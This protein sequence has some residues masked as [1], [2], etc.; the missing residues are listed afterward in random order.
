MKEEPKSPYSAVIAN[1]NQRTVNFQFWFEENHRPHLHKV[2]VLIRDNNPVVYTIYTELLQDL[3]HQ[4]RPFGYSK[5]EKSDYSK[6]EVVFVFDDRKLFDTSFGVFLE[7]IVVLMEDK[8][9]RYGI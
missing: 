9:K 7:K 2:R 8:I 5:I 6:D 4:V 3:G 1:Y